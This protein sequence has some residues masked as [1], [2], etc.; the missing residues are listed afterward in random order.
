MK[1]EF[2]STIEL[3][4]QITLNIMLNCTTLGVGKGVCLRMN[5][6]AIFSPLRS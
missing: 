6:Q 1:L 2:K 4:P 5:G 3:R